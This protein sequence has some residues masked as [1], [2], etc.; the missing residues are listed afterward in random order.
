MADLTL[1][2]AII[3]V[4]QAEQVHQQQGI[5]RGPTQDTLAAGDVDLVKGHKPKSYKEKRGQQQY[6]LKVQ[7]YQPEAQISQP[8]TLYKWCGR[9]TKHDRWQ[10]PAR[11][12]TCRTCKKT[13]HWVYGLP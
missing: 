4:R 7:S 8:P 1:E 3:T 6:Q 11:N 5:V 2:K 9:T 10:C 12:A 13:G